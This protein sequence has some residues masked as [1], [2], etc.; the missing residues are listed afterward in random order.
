MQLVAQRALS[1]ANLK[2]ISVGVQD[3]W[4]SS[5]ANKY[6]GLNVQVF[7]PDLHS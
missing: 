7:E 2:E 3:R 1:C 6:F 5:G 4:K